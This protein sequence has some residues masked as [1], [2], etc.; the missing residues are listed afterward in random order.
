MVIRASVLLLLLSPPIGNSP[1]SCSG[2]YPSKDCLDECFVD[3][4]SCQNWSYFSWAS[5]FIALP[6]SMHWKVKECSCDYIPWYF[7]FLSH[8]PFNWKSWPLVSPCCSRVDYIYLGFCRLFLGK[9]SPKI[10]EIDTPNFNVEETNLCVPIFLTS[11]CVAN[12]HL[13]A[14]E[15]NS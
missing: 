15:V 6:E 1:S 7:P 11:L 10:E 14:F 9:W 3:S 2:K 12:R 5:C 8:F 4:Y 13:C